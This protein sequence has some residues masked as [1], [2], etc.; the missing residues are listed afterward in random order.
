M[1]CYVPTGRSSSS[2][3]VLP[4]LSP[5]GTWWTGCH[6]H[7]TEGIYPVVPPACSAVFSGLKLDIALTGT[8]TIEIFTQ[9][10]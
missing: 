8:A 9:F 5:Y 7:I 10:W 2:N 6:S 4:I 1:L 3:F